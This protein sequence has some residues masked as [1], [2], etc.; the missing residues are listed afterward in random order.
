M[1]IVKTCK[2]L[3]FNV[4]K[5]TEDKSNNNLFNIINNELEKS[6]LIIKII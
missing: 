2:I 5:W 1:R 4:V 3:F 6:I